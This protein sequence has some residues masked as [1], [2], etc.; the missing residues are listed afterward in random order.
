MKRSYKIVLMLS[1][2]GVAMIILGM[3]IWINELS[4]K[5]YEFKIKLRDE[6][7]KNVKLQI[8]NDA[9]WSNYYSNVSDYNG[10]YEYY[11]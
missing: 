8:E 2:I 4:N 6:Q 3:S 7:V 1:I 11:E 10:E 9:L 5:C